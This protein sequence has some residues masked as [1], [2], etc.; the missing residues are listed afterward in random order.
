VFNA[1]SNFKGDPDFDDLSSY[2]GTD[3]FSTTG[4]EAADDDDL[5]KLL[6]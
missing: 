1:F 3:A 4:G 6:S 5:D 2:A